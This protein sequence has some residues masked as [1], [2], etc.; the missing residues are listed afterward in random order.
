MGGRRNKAR[1]EELSKKLISQRHLSKVTYRLQAQ[2]ANRIA[3]GEKTS[4]DVGTEGVEK[5]PNVMYFPFINSYIEGEGAEKIPNPCRH[6][7][8]PERKDLSE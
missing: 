2:E 8:A 5:S 1:R 3:S 6:G 4:H 7:R